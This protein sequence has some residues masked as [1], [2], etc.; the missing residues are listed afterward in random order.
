MELLT[1]SRGS[2]V[3]VQWIDLADAE[4]NRLRELGIREGAVLHIVNCGAFG[5]KVVAL[6]ADRFAID[7]QT[8][9]CIAVVPQ[10]VEQNMAMIGSADVASRKDQSILGQISKQAQT[11]HRHLLRLHRANSIPART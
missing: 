2:T 9:A 11:P 7:G 5:A 10:A 3:E 8:C 6:G 1:C 4:R